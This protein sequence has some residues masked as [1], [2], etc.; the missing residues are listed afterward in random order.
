MPPKIDQAAMQTQ[1]PGYPMRDLNAD[2]TFQDMDQ[3]VRPEGVQVTHRHGPHNVP[4]SNDH[5]VTESALG[6]QMGDPNPKV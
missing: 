5:E 1:A 4:L 3:V 6:P 2:S